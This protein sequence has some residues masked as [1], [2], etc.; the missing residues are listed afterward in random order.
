MSL[1]NGIYRLLQNI[2]D[3]QI[4][5]STGHQEGVSKACAKVSS[6]LKP[7]QQGIRTEI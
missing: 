7:K 2:R 1:K 4:G 6:G 3:T 5:L